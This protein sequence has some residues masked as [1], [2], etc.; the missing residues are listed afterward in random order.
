MKATLRS[1][2]VAT[3]VMFAAPALATPVGPP[4]G[5]CGVGQQ[6]STRYYGY[7]VT[8]IAGYWN[9]VSQPTY[10]LAAHYQQRGWLS[11]SWEGMKAILGQLR[12]DLLSQADKPGDNVRR[13][14]LAEQRSLQAHSDWD[15]YGGGGGQFSRGFSETHRPDG[16]RY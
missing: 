1:L 4:C 14:T 6:I 16:T 10:S 5:T 7:N 3:A 13:L 12:A 8:G 9:T 11:K 2:L 15:S